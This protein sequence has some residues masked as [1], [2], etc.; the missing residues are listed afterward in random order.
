MWT[1]A[2]HHPIVALLCLVVVGY[3]LTWTAEHVRFAV[4]AWRDH[5]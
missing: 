1:F 2:D 3:S 4:E 5:E